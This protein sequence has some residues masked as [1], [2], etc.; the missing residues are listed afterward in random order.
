M[1]G[2]GNGPQA[3][4]AQP[5]PAGSARRNRPEDDLACG[6]SPPPCSRTL[7]RPRKNFPLPIAN[8][9]YMVYYIP[10]INTAPTTT[11]FTEPKEV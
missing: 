8:Y 9:T 11:H 2:A 5:G 3:A 10:V 7:H 6:P 4:P 1:Q